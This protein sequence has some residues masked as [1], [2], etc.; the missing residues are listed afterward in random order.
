MRNEESVLR[1][2]G[3]CAKARG[4]IFGVPMIC[5]AMHA[6]KHVFLV[7]APSGNAKNSEKKLTDKCAYY[8]VPLRT[9][10]ADGETLSRA[11]GKTARLA[12]VAVT[13]ENLARLV[14]AKLDGIEQ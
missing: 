8:G 10:E 11:L 14:N 12:A 2:L 4:L 6:G 13:D 3:I 1:A 5:E 7:V 9:L